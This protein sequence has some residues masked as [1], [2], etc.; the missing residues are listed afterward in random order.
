MK[1]VPLLVVGATFA[2]VGIASAARRGALVVE[3]F[4]QPGHEF[5]S[6]Y[7]PG[8]H[9]YRSPRTAAGKR[10]LEQ[11]VRRNVLDETYRLHIP[12]VLPILCQ[13]MKEKRLPVLL[14]TAITR[15]TPHPDGY[16]A[17]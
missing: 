3:A 15:I 17:A 5:I 11:L 14:M 13:W 1:Y 2:G 4:S 9:W 10:L 6:S 7:R 8:E 12:A 16:V